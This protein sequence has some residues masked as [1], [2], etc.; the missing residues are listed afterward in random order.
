V[1]VVPAAFGPVSVEDGQPLHSYGFVEVMSVSRAGPAVGVLVVVG[2]ETHIHGAFCWSRTHA[3][4]PIGSVGGFDTGPGV[5]G[6]AVV[7][8]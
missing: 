5:A 1:Q 4:L 8:L 6:Y 2:Q 3:V 7:Q